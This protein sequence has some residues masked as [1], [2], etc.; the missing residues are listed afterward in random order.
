MPTVA[1]VVI[2]SQIY[3]RRVRV[4]TLP[5]ESLKILEI[6]LLPVCL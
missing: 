3:F 5:G 4:A 6:K 2:E 1:G